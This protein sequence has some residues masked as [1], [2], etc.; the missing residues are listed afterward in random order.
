MEE[1]KKEI[2]RVACPNCKVPLEVT[3]SRQEAVKTIN[4]P[5]CKTTFD[6]VFKPSGYQRPVDP[7]KT[8]LGMGMSMGMPCQGNEDKTS[9]PGG[10]ATN[11]QMGLRHMSSKPGCLFCNGQKYSLKLGQNTVGRISQQR[12]AD[13]ML[14]VTDPY[15]S[16]Q[17][18]II[19]VDMR[20][21]GTVQ[22]TIKN[23][24]NTNVTYVDGNLLNDEDIVFLRN[25]STI[26]M[27]DT[28]VTYFSEEA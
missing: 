2:R 23:Y 12:P 13:V 25:G 27:G 11:T 28:S 24:K 17:H 22:T 4:C 9:L 3:N 8:Q 1:N 26:R 21:D 14:N 18:I 5:R 20:H 19:R 6:V 10:H 7:N 15:M 16:R